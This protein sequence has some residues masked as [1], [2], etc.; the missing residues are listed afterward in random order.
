MKDIGEKIRS[1]PK[2]LQRPLMEQGKKMVE[3]HMKDIINMPPEEQ[4]AAIDKDLDLIQMMMKEGEKRRAEHDAANPSG[5]TDG[6]S[7]DAKPAAGSP[8]SNDAGG[9]P[10]G[11]MNHNQMLSSTTGETR[12]QW[13]HYMELLHTRAVERGMSFPGNERRPVAISGMWV[14]AT[15]R[16]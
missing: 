6:T 1:L 4:T 12:A 10:R 15:A 9:P 7:A 2:D 14:G 5:K 16:R 13:H 8:G 3:Q 11:P